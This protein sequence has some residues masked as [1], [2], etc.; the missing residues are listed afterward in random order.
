[1]DAARYLPATI[2]C[3]HF[4]FSQAT[5]RFPPD[6]QE[7]ML[8][9]LFKVSAEM[10]VTAAYAVYHCLR[11]PS[12]HLFVHGDLLYGSVLFMLTVMHMLTATH[13]IEPRAPASKFTKMLVDCSCLILARY[14]QP[15]PIQDCPTIESLSR[16]VA[17]M[18]YRNST[19][20][21]DYCPGI[22][23]ASIL[24]VDLTVVIRAFAKTISGRTYSAATIFAASQCLITMLERGSP[25]FQSPQ[26]KRV[27]HQD[28]HLA[29]L[30]LCL[31]TRLMLAGPT[32]KL[33]EIVWNRFA[34]IYNEGLNEVLD[35][36]LA[37]T[38]AS[39]YEAIIIRWFRVHQRLVANPQFLL[40]V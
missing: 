11:R 4:I 5:I 36:G 27:L 12:G 38:L 7:A 28:I 10:R 22:H 15:V 32:A 8:N 35:K 24:D 33:I 30:S 13:A 40:I 20:I 9:T 21:Q 34:H 6:I 29:L 2:Q 37:T 26:F 25:F 31:D 39:P 18:L 17:A 1:M 23:R 3:F 19:S 14:S 16:Y